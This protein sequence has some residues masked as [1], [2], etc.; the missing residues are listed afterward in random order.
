[1]SNNKK[2]KIYEISLM[3]LAAIIVAIYFSLTPVQE[4]WYTSRTFLLL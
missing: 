3:E 1:M 4:S 2:N